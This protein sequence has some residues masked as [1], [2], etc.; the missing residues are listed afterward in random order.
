[1]YAKASFPSSDNRV[2]CILDLVHLDVCGPISHV[3]LSGHEYD[4]IFIDD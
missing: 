1:M 4:V 2:A 3:L